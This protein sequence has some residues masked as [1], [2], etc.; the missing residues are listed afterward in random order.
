MLETAAILS[1]C[2]FMTYC[3]VKHTAPIQKL[4]LAK[5]SMLPM[6]LLLPILLAL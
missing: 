1:T 2:S 4:G 3:G 5:L 6:L